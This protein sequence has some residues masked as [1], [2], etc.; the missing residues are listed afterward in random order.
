MKVFRKVSKYGRYIGR[1][2][3]SSEK[4]LIDLVVLIIPIAM[5]YEAFSRYAFSKTPM[6]LEEFILL[7]AAYGY[8]IGAA[9]ASR[10]QVHITVTLLDAIKLPEAVRK[11]LAVFSSFV[12]FAIALV[13]FWYALDY[14]LF[15]SERGMQLVPFTW[16][17]WVWTV[18]MP[19]GLIILSLYE[20]RNMIR[21]IRAIRGKEESGTSPTNVAGQGS[22][23]L[24]VA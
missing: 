6:G 8:F 11:Y 4:G 12:C 16:P 13:F 20:L 1:V 18:S 14:N 9:H 10:N 24:D 7:L 2:W 17:F 19:I 3:N 22:G 5:A 21:N 23:S 15:L